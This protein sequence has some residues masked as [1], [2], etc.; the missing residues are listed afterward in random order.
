L[1]DLA[2]KAKPHRDVTLLTPARHSFSGEVGISLSS[3]R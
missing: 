1:P 3:F 2:Q